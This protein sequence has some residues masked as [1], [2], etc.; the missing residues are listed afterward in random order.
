MNC[1]NR[2]EGVYRFQGHTPKRDN[3][4]QKEEE[5]AKQR[6]GIS[7]WNPSL[8]GTMDGILSTYPKRTGKNPETCDKTPSVNSIFSF[9]VFLLF[10]STQSFRHD[11]FIDL[12]QSLYKL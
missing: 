7:F 2:K 1:A 11:Q 8:V 12:S 4:V 10:Y 9:F 3:H 6:E 5:S